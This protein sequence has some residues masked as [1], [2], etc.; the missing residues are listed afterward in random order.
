MSCANDYL[1]HIVKL[2]KRVKL[3]I[4]IS[5]LREGF[6]RHLLYREAEK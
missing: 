5:V 3:R 4:C 1:L 2:M 6:Y